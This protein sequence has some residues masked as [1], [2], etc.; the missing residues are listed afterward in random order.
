[1][2]FDKPKDIFSPEQQ[3]MIIAAIKEAEMQT[4]G[5]VKVHVEPFCKTDPMQRALQVFD[6]LELYRTAQRNGVLFYLAYDD[7]KF[8]ILGDEGI[9]NK[10][11]QTFWDTTKEKMA[12]HL[13][14]GEYTEAVCEGVK[15]A[16]EQLKA[17]FPYTRND[18]NELSNDISFGGHNA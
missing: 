5:E 4:S 10:V 14:I 2:L 8:A 15:M 13:K 18:K 7:H 3:E 16:G 12:A 6:E 11:G 1:M 9:H 17:Y